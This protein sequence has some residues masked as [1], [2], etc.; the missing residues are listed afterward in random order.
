VALSQRN[1]ELARSS[2]T[3]SMQLSLATGRRLAIARGLEALGV[4]A[5]A[6]GD[7]SRAIRLEGAGLALR[8]AAGHVSPV[9]ARARIDALFDAARQRL[10][11]AAAAAL[12]AEGRAMTRDEA[13]RL[14]TEPAGAARAGAARAGGTQGPGGAKGAGGPSVLTAR[15]LE[16]AALI[17]RGLTNRG[18]ADEL[19]IS[20]LT[21]ARHVAN[22]F[23]KLGCSSRTQV[24]AWVA[25]REAGRGS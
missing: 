19:V 3:E 25:D 10:G 11:T 13:I 23:A 4:L 17:A 18:I 1:L 22:I 12:L 8:E 20:P 6:E 16:I 7:P 9:P 5:L 14:G 21:V 15:E 2:L 24:A